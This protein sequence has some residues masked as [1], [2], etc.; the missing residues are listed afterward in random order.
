MRGLHCQKN[1][2]NDQKAKVGLPPH[3][4]YSP[5]IAPSDLFLFRRI[6]NDLE[7]VRFEDSNAVISYAQEWVR[8]QPKN[9]WE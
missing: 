6:Q 9:I 1:N 8:T 4:P 2:R 5:D 3:P 7:R